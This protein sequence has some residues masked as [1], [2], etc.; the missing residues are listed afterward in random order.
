ME[1]ADLNAAH[2]LVEVVQA[3]SFTAAGRALGLPK[4]TLSRKVSELER[5]LGARL[6]HR[7]TRQLSLTDVGA[8]YYERALRAVQDLAEAESL[9]VDS[10]NVPRGVLRVTAPPELGASFLA[11]TLPDFCAAHP[12]V[13]VVLDLS[14][15]HVDLVAEGFDL[16]LRAGTLPDSSLIAKR[17]FSG[18]HN[19][20]A[21][22]QYL[23]RRGEPRQP[24]EIP[25]HDCLVFG[26]QPEATWTLES[27]RRRARISVRGRVAIRDYGYLRSTAVAGAG[28]AILPD[29]LVGADLHHGRLRRVLPDYS[30]ATDALY[31]VYPSR[32]FLPAKTSAFVSFIEQRFAQWHQMCG[33]ERCSK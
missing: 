16:A 30:H 11:R 3:G 7:S 21:S 24:E 2:L 33:S 23:E 15:R 31:V 8:A 29:L 10:Q 4:S 27:S 19:L 20:Y 22:P 28:I 25:Q 18:T 5:R 32:E 6:L 26:R 13:D 12:E 1:H 17:V 14:G 9:V